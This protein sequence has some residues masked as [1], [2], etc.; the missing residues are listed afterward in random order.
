M[1]QSRYQS[2]GTSSLGTL[3]MFKAFDIPTIDQQTGLNIVVGLAIVCLV[4][5]I[6][7]RGDNLH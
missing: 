5:I 1:Q 3:N 4:L 7:F 6:A 2:T